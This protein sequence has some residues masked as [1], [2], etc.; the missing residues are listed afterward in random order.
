MGILSW[1]AMGLIVGVLAK[2]IMPG[3]DPGGI[4]ITILIGIAGAFLGGY[5]GSFLGVGTVT[6]FNMISLLLAIGGALLLLILYRLIK[7]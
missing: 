4:I 2:L 1:I 5:I 7:R 6:G 3:K